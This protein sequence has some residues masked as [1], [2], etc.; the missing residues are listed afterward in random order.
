MAKKNRDD[1]KGRFKDGDK[2]TQS[3]FENLMDSYINQLDDGISQPEGNDVPLKVNAMPANAKVLDFADEHGAIEWGVSTANG[4]TIKDNMNENRLFIKQTTG[5]VGVSTASPSARLH[6]ARSVQGDNGVKIDGP[7]SV[8][9]TSTELLTVKPNNLINPVL[10]VDEQGKLATKG[11]IETESDLV[12]SGSAVINSNSMLKGTLDVE[13]PV[14]FDQTLAVKEAVSLEKSVDIGE[15]LTVTGSTTINNTLTVASSTTLGN[16][17][18]DL[19]TIKGKLVSANSSGN[20][21]IEDSVN[22][23]ESLTVADAVDLNSNLTVD[24][25]LLAKRN[26]TFEKNITAQS[27]SASNLTIDESTTLNGEVSIDD[28]LAVLGDLSVTGAVNLTH[29]LQ[30]QD[31][32]TVSEFSTDNTL[33]DNSDSAVPTEKAVKTYVDTKDSNMRTYID[34]RLPAGVIVMWS[35]ASDTIPIGW[36]ICDGSNGTPNLQDR[37]IVGAGSSYQVEDKGGENTVTLTA[38]QSGLPSHRHSGSTSEDGTHTHT[39]T[40]PMDDTA[41]GSLIFGGEKST[42][43]ET[44][45]TYTTSS[46]GAHTHTVTTTYESQNAAEAHENRPPYYAL[47]YIIKVI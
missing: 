8:E 4:L 23:S 14:T 12:V 40:I 19:T 17:D 44:S 29:S 7:V 45:N 11:N 33:A 10:S 27:V 32:T 25:L 9:L 24:G 28:N 2:P 41:G 37:F 30:L 31:G 39:V 46:D 1:L 13:Q 38:N 5:E 21:E 16:F 3:D 20:I 34:E 47:Y 22:I 36:A 43:K 26:A 15:T 42:G 35:G 6:V 18:S